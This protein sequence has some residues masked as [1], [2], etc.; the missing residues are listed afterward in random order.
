MTGKTR[1]N[2]RSALLGLMLAALASRGAVAQQSPR[3]GAAAQD[4][5]QTTVTLN[6]NRVPIDQIVQFLSETAHKPVL[7]QKDI[8][9]ELTVTSPVPVTRRRAVD[10]II[11]ALRLENI[12]VIEVDDKLQIVTAATL[13]GMQFKSIE[14]AVDLQSL[15]DSLEIA[16]R[17]YRPKFITPEN[18]RRHLDR[19]VPDSAITMDAKSGTLI[20]T[21]QIVQLKRYDRVIRAL[22]TINVSDRTIEIFKLE[23][24]DAVELGLLISNIMMNA[25][26]TGPGAPVDPST[27]ARTM[28]FFSRRATQGRF[29]GREMAASMPIV[30]GE[31]TLI[32]DPRNNW[33]I[34]TCPKTLLAEIT[35]LVR[36][37][38]LEKMVDVQPRFLDLKHIDATTAATVITDLFRDT[39]T[40]AAKD[41][42]K[43]VP[44]DSGSSLVVMSSAINFEIITRI[45]RELDSPDAERKETR[46]YTVVNLP[47]TDLADQLNK[48]YDDDPNRNRSSYSYY[49]NST[50]SGSSSRPT[51]VPSPRTNTVMALAKPRDFPFI[52]KMMK[53]LDIPMQT[54]AFEPRV[55][56]IRHTDANEMV[57]VLDTLFKEKNA[58]RRG[59]DE[60]Y[61]WRPSGNRQQSN[62]L[63][64]LF[65]EIRF[66]VDKVTN[67]IVA[68]SSNPKNYEVIDRM[69][70]QLDQVDPESTDV[71]VYELKY[72]EAVDVANHLNN[73]FSEGPVQQPNQPQPTPSPSSSSSKSSSSTETAEVVAEAVRTVVY[74]WQ[75]SGGSKKPEEERPINTMVGQVRVVPDTRSNKIMVAAPSIYFDAIRSVIEDLDRPEPQVHVTAR[76][77]EIVRGR[78]RRVGLRWTPDPGSID[79]AE[80]DNAVAAMGRLGFLDSF[81]GGGGPTAVKSTTIGRGVAN[82]GITRTIEGT[83]D[84]GNT[85]LGADLNLTLLI[86]LLLKNTQAKVVSEPKITINNNEPG[87]IFVGSEYPFKV[88][89]QTTDTGTVTFGVEYRPVGIKLN[90]T[91]HINHD[92]NVVLSASL[93]NSKVR[94]GE[95]ID[96]QIVTDKTEFHTELALESGQT[97]V[98]GGVVIDDQYQS[99]REIPYL[100]KIPGIG[101]LFRKSD[102]SKTSRELV[103]FITPEV[104]NTR[105]EDDAILEKAEKKLEEMERPLEEAKP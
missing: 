11:D 95:F 69:I 48:L 100:G 15:P 49:Y 91:P 39:F 59:G 4:D 79:P 93:E 55:Y 16:Q 7:K 58:S 75:A 51:F 14:E 10:L 2:T 81:G 104:L 6:L 12:L 27:A 52:E 76:F 21:D 66:V 19:L 77:V 82:E 60:D 34:V 96:G 31:L 3:A 97:M 32:P 101:A 25:T 70:K 99:G 24:A 87:R 18:L 5:D 72:A 33:L 67:T 30:T 43:V 89:S 36:D 38:D 84:P 90:V 102:R 46:T 73:L 29:S 9:L 68:L 92:G 28:E 42:I 83:I 61:F 71:L 41:V 44:D 8:N 56:R 63:Q 65:G 88:N 35:R 13:K 23:H 17:I 47:A 53:E 1:M 37:F 40:G 86:Q 50:P 98:I 26:A 62:S 80:L 94:P 85:I 105:A 22:D 45:A 103:V 78:E 64:A 74:P 20:I 57:K 54:G